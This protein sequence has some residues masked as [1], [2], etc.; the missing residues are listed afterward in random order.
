MTTVKLFTLQ[1]GLQAKY[2]RITHYVMEY[3]KKI[4]MDHF[5]VEKCH[6]SKHVWAKPYTINI[7]IKVLSLSPNNY[8]CQV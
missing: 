5:V 4:S 1:N 7:A 2:D 8:F 6:R 3:K